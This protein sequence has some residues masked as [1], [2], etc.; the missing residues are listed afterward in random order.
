[1]LLNIQTSTIFNAVPLP[2]IPRLA[3]R[4]LSGLAKL[5]RDETLVADWSAPSQIVPEIFQTSRRATF[6][7]RARRS[8]ST[9]T[10]A[11][12]GLL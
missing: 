6:G 3:L 4:S 8:V 2:G 1:M 5:A 9:R 10:R 11:V 12:R 7:R